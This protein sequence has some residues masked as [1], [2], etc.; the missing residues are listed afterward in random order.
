VLAYSTA[1]VLE[2][3]V[4]LEVDQD[5]LSATA[6][7]DEYAVADIR[8]AVVGEEEV[9]IGVRSPNGWGWR[10]FGTYGVR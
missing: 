9:L 10:R 8:E 5:V 3:M 6:R 2:R 7:A 4:A 1:E